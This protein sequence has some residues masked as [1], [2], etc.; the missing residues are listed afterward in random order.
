MYMLLAVMVLAVMAAGAVLVGHFARFAGA[1][2]E[3]VVEADRFAR[4]GGATVVEAAG[5][6][7]G[8]DVVETVMVDEVQHHW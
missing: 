1:G 8:T 5:R 3:S 2:V 4:A 6:A 7:P